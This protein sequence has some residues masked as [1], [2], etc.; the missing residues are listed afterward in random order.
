MRIRPTR[1]RRNTGLVTICD[2]T[3]FFIRTHTLNLSPRAG[4]FV[5]C[6]DRGVRIH[7]TLKL[8][9]DPQ[10]RLLG[11]DYELLFWIFE[12]CKFLWT[13]REAV[14]RGQHARAG[15]S[16]TCQVRPTLVVV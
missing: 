2:Y 3:L 4:G 6:L 13:E 5:G 8:F 12:D 10:S 1:I 9:A 7:G 15:S 16:V 11:S 14:S